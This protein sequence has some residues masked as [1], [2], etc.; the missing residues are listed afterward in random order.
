MNNLGFKEKQTIGVPEPSPKNK[1]RYPSVTLYG[2]QVKAVKNLKVGDKCIIEF[3]ATVS[4][5]QKCET[6][7]PC[8]GVKATFD[9][10]SADVEPTNGKTYNDM[11]DAAEAGKKEY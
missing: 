9:L 7:D 8:E 4:G 1:T 6:W 2:E 10:I 11:E 3:K 5:T